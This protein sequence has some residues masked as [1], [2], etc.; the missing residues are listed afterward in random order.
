MWILL[1]VVGLSLFLSCSPQ[2]A[3]QVGSGNAGD[4]VSAPGSPAIHP[5]IALP[6]SYGQ[7]SCDWLSDGDVCI[8]TAEGCAPGEKP[9][10][11]CVCSY[12]GPLLRFTCET[13]FHNC[14]PLVGIDENPDGLN[15]RR[16][17]NPGFRSL[18]TFSASERRIG[19]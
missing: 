1:V 2:T 15:W 14:L 11:V 5:Y 10:N 8:W 13:P 7:F 3:R 19:Q 12:D 16:M 18:G 4:D 6:N 9:D 17:P